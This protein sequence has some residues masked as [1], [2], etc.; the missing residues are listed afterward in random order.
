MT[1]TTAKE[2]MKKGSMRGGENPCAPTMPCCA[3]VHRDLAVAPRPFLLSRAGQEPLIGCCSGERS[4]AST[5]ETGTEFASYA[6][7][8]LI[9]TAKVS[10]LLSP[11]TKARQPQSWHEP[12]QLATSTTSSGFCARK[13]KNVRKNPAQRGRDN[14]RAT[15][16]CFKPVTRW[17]W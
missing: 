15:L 16:F 5:R 14:S 3:T 9:C 2:V 6:S 12:G 17:S 11:G 8:F 4:Q 7:E 10:H 1:C 13:A